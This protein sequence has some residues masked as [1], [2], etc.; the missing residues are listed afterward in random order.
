MKYGLYLSLIFLFLTFF[1]TPIIAQDESNDSPLFLIHQDKVFP[2]KVEQ[3]EKALKDFKDL[4]KKSNVDEMSFTVAQM[5]Y[6]T[7]SA[8]IPVE[9]Y[10]GLANHFAMSE[11]M[12]KKVGK[13][14]FQNALAQFDGCYNSHEN[15]LLRMRKDLSHKPA[16]GLDPEEGLNFRHFDF[17]HVIPGKGTEMIEVF[18]EWKAIYE[19]HNI[20]W[21]YRVYQGDLGV[22]GPMFMM[23]KPFENRSD[24]ASKSDEIGKILGK[25]QSMI[26]DKATELMIKFEHNNGR[27][28]PDLAY[29]KE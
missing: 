21:G 23:V 4:L 8:V 1:I 13:E 3:Y 17:L 6:F 22:D 5:E 27:M 25:D 14:N 29:K 9:N 10:E 20:E 24:W 15:Y 11:G 19:K 12:I 2:H 28:R 26:Q 7:F 18:K 16:Y